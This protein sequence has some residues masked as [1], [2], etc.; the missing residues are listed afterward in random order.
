MRDLACHEITHF[1]A[2]WHDE[3][4][5]T[6]EGMVQEAALPVLEEIERIGKA[7]FSDRKGRSGPARSKASRSLQQDLELSIRR[8]A[9]GIL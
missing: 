7:A 4:F 5:T 2:G 6:A 8:A 1:F 9:G 3:N